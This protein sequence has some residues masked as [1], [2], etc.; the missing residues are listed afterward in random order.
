M[1]AMA[2]LHANAKWLLIISTIFNLSIALSNTFVNVYLW[3]VDKTYG[4]IG[5]YN[6]LLYIVTA[7]M[8][9]VA[10]FLAG[11]IGAVWTLR[12]GIL[13]HVVFYALTLVGGQAVANMPYLLGIVMG[14]A[15]GMYWFS[16]NTLSLG[17]T[18]DG[19]RD[20]F[21]GLNGVTG[22]L[23]GMLAPPI[24][25]FLISRED[26]L[27][28]PITGYHV[29]F[30]LSLGL[31][32]LAT[33]LTTRIRTHARE[34]QLRMS[35]AF[36]SLRHRWWRLLMVGC[37]AYG[38]REGVFL[39][40]IGLLMYV[41]TNSEMRL[42]EFA[43]MQSALSFVSFYVVGRIV[44]PK[45]RLKV[46][47]AGAILMAGA[48]LFFLLPIR[49]ITIVLYGC[50]I[51]LVLPLFLV[52]LQGFVF[53]GISALSRAS[54]SED[55]VAKEPDASNE[56]IVL[57]EIF[58]NLGR[59]IGILG[60][61]ILVKTRTGVEFVPELAVGLGFTQLLT[62]I[63]LQKSGIESVCAGGEQGDGQNK[64]IP[65]GRPVWSMQNEETGRPPRGLKST[66]RRSP[67]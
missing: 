55:G 48:A 23:A 8:F 33:F 41:S 5:V 3:K 6:L 16:F 4:S 38:M 45:N 56:Q 15:G 62:W 44:R 18:N 51:A 9:L 26:R 67:R 65:S 64:V 58:E 27:V 57:R 39:F 30:G 59:V 60:F 52:S 40:L 14:C 2:S 24:A 32:V 17:F 46:L 53:D 22:A 10:G 7:L 54:R 34:P 13:W 31:F 29:I 42:G 66:S 47:R 61:L 21:F 11:K 1:G 43:L 63:F 25:G 50:V 20:G 36:A 49:P 35:I 37:T 19:K 12:I 28:G